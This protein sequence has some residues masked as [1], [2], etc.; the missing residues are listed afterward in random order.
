MYEVP[1][2]PNVE[3]VII[4]PECVRGKADALFELKD[5]RVQLKKEAVERSTDANGSLA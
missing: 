3:K 5:N 2:D 4:T 1:S